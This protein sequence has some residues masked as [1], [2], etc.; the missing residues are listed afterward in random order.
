MLP[1]IMRQMLVWKHRRSSLFTT[2]RPSEVILQTQNIIF[3]QIITSLHFNEN[4]RLSTPVFHS[5]RRANRDIDCL[6][7]FDQHLAI[8]ERHVCSSLYYNPVFGSLG[9][10]LVTQT[11]SG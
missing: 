4:K 5:M 2:R 11:F 3:A 6:T 7:C 9:M 8:V 10:L 1:R